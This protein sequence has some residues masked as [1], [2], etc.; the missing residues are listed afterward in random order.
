MATQQLQIRKA[1]TD[2]EASGAKLHSLQAQLQVGVFLP[3]ALH[4]FLHGPQELD[5]IVSIAAY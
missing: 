2:A 3:C 1:D 4:H 5:C